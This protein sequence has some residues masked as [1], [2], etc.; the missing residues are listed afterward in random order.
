M[1]L[2][3]LMMVAAVMPWSLSAV[4]GD[5]HWSG[6]IQ[7]GQTVEIKGVNGA[8]RAQLSTSREVIVDAHK[9]G[10]RSDP[11]TV[12][13]EAVPH[14]GG[15]TLCAVYP[16]VDG[17]ANECKPGKEGRM[18][19][20]DNDVNV[21]FTVQVPAGVRLVAKTVNGIIE[22]NQLK[23]D[24]GAETTNGKIQISTSEAGRAKTVN[25]TIVAAIGRTDG[26]DPLHFE[27]VNGSVE[28]RL[29]AG[30]NADVHAST[31]NGQINTEFPMTVSG[32]F[33]PKS[34]NGKIGSGGRE[35]RVST[36][37]GGVDLKKG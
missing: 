37:N 20:R 17:R 32:K 18:N 2:S 27:T 7:P 29:P 14:A 21:E 15:I 36:V 33:G 34:L 31:T 30:T 23:S 22:A 25:G 28:L 24:I 35:I 8:I 5:F 12:H 9:K 6:A 16:N 10:R 13:I 4:E 1:R 19:T 26:A 3:A 11:S